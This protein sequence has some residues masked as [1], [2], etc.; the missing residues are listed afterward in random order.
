[1]GSRTSSAFDLTTVTSQLRWRAEPS[2]VPKA[3]LTRDTKEIRTSIKRK[4]LG[5]YNS[6][7]GTKVKHYLRDG[8][9][10]M[11]GQLQYNY[12]YVKLLT[13]Y[14]IERLEWCTAPVVDRVNLS[15]KLEH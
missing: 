10:W 4:S 6:E 12:N 15:L 5:I 3:R 11:V 7:Q 13:N 9:I 1:M 8:L 2:V 14:V